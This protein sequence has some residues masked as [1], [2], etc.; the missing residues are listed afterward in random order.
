M[1]IYIHKKSVCIYL[2]ILTGCLIFS[3][4]YGGP[5][6][7]ALLYAL[8]LIIPFSMIYIFLNYRFLS[9]YQ[10]AEAHKLTKGEDYSYNAI[11]ENSG[12][13][14]IHGMK[15]GVYT[16]RC[17]LYEIEDGKAVSLNACEKLNL[18]SKINCLYAGAYYVGLDSVSFTDPFNIFAVKCDI[19]Y[20]FRAI[21]SPRITD[22]AD[23]ALD[24][25]NIVNSTG[26][27]ST[28]MPEDIPSGNLRAYQ[29]GDPISAVNWKVSARLSELVVKMPDPMEKRTVSI[30]M[31]AAD[32]PEIDR[33]TE[34]LKKRDRFLEFAV[35]AAWH[36][37]RQ[38]LPVKMVYPA[39]NV[40]ESVV[41]S[42]ES[43][44]DFYS[45][46]DD[47]ILYASESDFRE[48]D[49]RF[50]DIKMGDY[51]GDTWIIIREDY[52][53]CEDFCTVIG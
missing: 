29:R 12:L 4:F 47:G 2:L 18:S 13:L 3:S 39:G 9:I 22:M 15:I 32:I 11:L 1:R 36:F 27:R 37:G 46:I 53:N 20:S 23:R 19:P 5:V 34:F 6:S 42:Y 16:D 38:H 45:I 25:E 8:L 48:M 30:L 10:E 44:M 51:D 40:K 52:E 35:S 33:D 17:R 41:D 24:L 21:V 50:E 28:S 43:F 14:P 49:R 31:K 26:F 7:Y